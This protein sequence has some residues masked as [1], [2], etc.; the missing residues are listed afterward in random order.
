ME[1]AIASVR[2]PAVWSRISDIRLRSLLPGSKGLER[3]T[4]TLD[5]CGAMSGLDQ[6]HGQEACATYLI[7]DI[8]SH[9][10]TDYRLLLSLN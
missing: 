3:G 7:S 4:D 5:L 8:R 10:I 9:L 6:L 2:I 1:D